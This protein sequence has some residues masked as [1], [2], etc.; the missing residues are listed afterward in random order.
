MIGLP[1]PLDRDDFIWPPC[2]QDRRLPASGGFSGRDLFTGDLD[3]TL[4]DENLNIVDFSN[5]TNE[6]E[7]VT[8]PRDGNYFIEVSAFSGI[9]EVHSATECGQLGATHQRGSTDFVV[10]KWLYS[11]ELQ[12]DDIEHGQCAG[13][14]LQASDDT[15]KSL[16]HQ[17]SRR[18]THPQ[19]ALHWHAGAPP[20][21]PDITKRNRSWLFST[22]KA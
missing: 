17:A 16:A 20:F 2:N 7:S 9:S 10:E 1:L 11:L 15:V 6:F 19:I 13:H 4:Y 3:L 18:P 8:V 22:P 5:D 14:P 12:P 21:A